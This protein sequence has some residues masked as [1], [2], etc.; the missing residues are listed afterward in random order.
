MRKCKQKRPITVLKKSFAI[1]ISGEQHH[2][3]LKLR[4]NALEIRGPARGAG[5]AEMGFRAGQCLR[6]GNVVFEVS[7]LSDSGS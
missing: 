5:G 6:P 1:N 2:F 4:G 7:D 3:A